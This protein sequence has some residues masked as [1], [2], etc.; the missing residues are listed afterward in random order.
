MKKI[1]SCCIIA[2]SL[3][4]S[5]ISETEHQKVINEKI[6]ISAENEKLKSELE[7]IK[8]GAPN[9]IAD[10]KKF[11]KAKEFSKAREKF[12]TLLEKHPDL[13]QSLEAKKYLATIDEE[14]LW[15]NASQS[16][17]ISVTEKYIS[18]YPKGNYISKAN[19]R[20]EELKI[21][22]MQKA[23]DNAVSEN[24]SYAWKSFLEDYPN[25]KNASAI[26][27]KIIRLEVDEIMGNRNTGQMP[28][29]NQ[30]GYSSS[31]T[32]SVEITNNTG[33]SLIV[34]YS[35]VDVKM[36][37]IPQGGTRRV[38]LSSGTYKVAASACGENYAGTENLSGS[39]NSTFYIETRRY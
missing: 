35:G 37:E 14:E 7:E 22:N 38:N 24:S 10:G 30:Y 33:C 3:F 27:D 17:D 21:L 2:T 15:Q 16:D 23:Y 13:P 32:S 1:I 8:F 12:Q 9:L 5:C 28:T 31:S 34:R 19:A 36:I 39:Y 6:E 20:K 25:H 11:F 26:R 29:F 4:S 18:Q